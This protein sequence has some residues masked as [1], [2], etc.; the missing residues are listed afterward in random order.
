MASSSDRRLRFGILGCARITRSG[1]VPGILGSSHGE[2]TALASRREDTARA[3]AAEFAIPRFHG[4]YEA[5]LDDPEVD[6][7]YIPLSNEL[8]AR[9]T[10]AAAD[11]RKHVLC[12]KPLALDRAEAESM[13]AYCADRGVML[14]EA[15]MWRHQPRSQA[16]QR[17]VREGALGRIGTVRVSFSFPIDRSD[18]RLDPARGGGALWDIGYYGVSTARFYVGG[19]PELVHAVSRMGETG[20]DLSTSILMRFPNGATALIDCSF[21]QPYRCAYELVGENAAIAVPDAFL[22][23]P[24]MTVAYLRDNAGETRELQFDGQNQYSAMVDSF[25]QAVR[26]GG[27]LADP[28]ENGVAQIRVLDQIRKAA[29]HA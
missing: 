10:R 4:T 7:V 15:A 11:A 16:I 28:A 24:D 2:L 27:A 25:V 17:M 23:P 12:E 6:A 8:H 1:L 14:M 9:W 19:E 3:W 13:S 21:E 29:A 22:P 20:V 26:T 18:W 5:L